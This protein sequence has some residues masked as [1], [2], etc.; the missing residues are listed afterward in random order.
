MDLCLHLGQVE[1]VVEANGF[2]H[3]G[4]AMT[5]KQRVRGA[6]KGGFSYWSL[7]HR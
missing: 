5:L 3:S 4:G 6:V 1:D 7:P 2:E